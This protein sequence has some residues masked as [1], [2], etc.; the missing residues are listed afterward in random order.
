LVICR[1]RSFLGARRFEPDDQA[2][3]VN[4]NADHLLCNHA[5]IVRLCAAG[6]WLALPGA[7]MLIH[8]FD[9]NV[10]D[11][12]CGNAGDR[13]DRYRHGFALEMRQRDVIAIADSS[14]SGV[15]RDHA[16]AGIV[17]Q[18][19]SQEM[20]GFGFGVTSVGPLIAELLLNCIKKL[21]IHDRWLLAG[22][23]F[24]LVFDLADIEPVTQQIE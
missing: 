14:F 23:D 3:L 5:A 17:E 19:A 8:R 18:Q 9:N 16:V 13:S 20:V 4:I 1:I 2:I 15:G 6:S 10:F 24:T 11:V 12:G 22:Q 21:P 7:K